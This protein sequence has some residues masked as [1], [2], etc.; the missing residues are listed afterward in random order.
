M[1]KITSIILSSLCMIFLFLSC[2]SDLD[3]DLES[4]IEELELATEAKTK[5]LAEEITEPIEPLEIDPT[6]FD[7]YLEFK[8]KNNFQLPQPMTAYANQPMTYSNYY[9]ES[10]LDDNIYAIRDIPVTL[11]LR[12]GG[13]LILST[14]GKGKELIFLQKPPGASTG[15]GRTQRVKQT[16]YFYFKAIPSTT[17]VPYLLYSYVEETP[18]SVGTYSNNP[19]NPVLFTT[20]DENGPL[21]SASFT[22]SPSNHNGY[23]KWQ[24]NA[25]I[26]QGG[27]GAWWD[28]YY[29]VAENRGNRTG[30]SQYSGNAAQEWI[31]TPNKTFNLDDLQFS[32]SHNTRVIRQG[33]EKISG[34][35]K[36]ELKNTI[37]PNVNIYFP[38]NRQETSLFKENTGINF[39]L[40]D[41]GKKFRLP[42]IINGQINTF[43]SQSDPYVAEYSET[44]QTFIK[45]F[46]SY[47]GANLEPR[48]KLEAIYTYHWYDVEVDY[49]VKISA[50]WSTGMRPSTVSKRETTLKGIWKG[51]IW[52]DERD[53]VY[54]RFINLDTNQII[55]EGYIDISNYSKSSDQPIIKMT[56]TRAK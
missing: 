3:S 6:L 17:G 45:E 50:S 28:T 21:Y 10:T 18:I 23:L 47:L 15:G 49:T 2:Q 42:T 9:Y 13:N 20:K 39:K 32:N 55:E 52:T 7:Q 14:D 26:A 36:N 34:G 12:G 30:F 46:N 1:K 4:K 54:Y 48:T 33:T 53:P 35:D 16:D 25:L 31:I 44:E 24:S 27:S 56:K 40:S 37:R 29:K 19:N 38:M 5:V 22:F 43:P 11:Y 8:K 41:G 51:R